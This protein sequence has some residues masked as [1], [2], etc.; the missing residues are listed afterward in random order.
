MAN[1][2]YHGRDHIR[3]AIEA[4]FE[5]LGNYR[6]VAEA[7]GVS[8]GTAWRMI[9]ERYYWPSDEEVKEKI[10]KAGL[11]R[12]IMVGVRPLP[13]KFPYNAKESE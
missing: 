12:G 13:E 9:N 1:R 2:K 4:D 5:R 11:A 6:A 7:W 8:S 10:Q 3:R